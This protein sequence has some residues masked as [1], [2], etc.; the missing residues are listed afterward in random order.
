MAGVGVERHITQ[1]A[2]FGEVFF[3]RGN[4]ARH[5]AVR[6]HRLGTVG[7]FS[8]LVDHREQRHARHAQLH[9]FF[10]DGEQFVERVAR[11]ARHRW[12][13]LHQPGTNI[14]LVVDEHR[15]DQIV[16][17]ENIFLHQTARKLG[18]AVAAH[19]PPGKFS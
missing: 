13:R 18:L 2:Q 19:A 8:F 5:Q 1:H 11:Y 12:H 16:G 15:V 3:Q 14:A 9:G 7:A 17:G 6:V 10:G 4:D